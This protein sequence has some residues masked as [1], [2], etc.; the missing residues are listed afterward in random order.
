M[1]G[2]L[3]ASR[4]TLTFEIGTTGT[5][6]PIFRNKNFNNIKTLASDEQLRNTG[7]ALATLQKHSLEKMD[8]SNTIS[9]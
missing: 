2:V 1:D 8:R 9:L 6:D 3:V 7:I 5:G 4:L